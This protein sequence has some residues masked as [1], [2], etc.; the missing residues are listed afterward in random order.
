MPDKTLVCKDCGAEFAF[1]E[2]EQAFYKEKGFE[3]EPVRCP[4][5]R[6]A[7]KN[8]RRQQQG[9]YDNRF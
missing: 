6:R 2:G 4:D 9:G 7:R 3:N 1:T 5:C 8:A